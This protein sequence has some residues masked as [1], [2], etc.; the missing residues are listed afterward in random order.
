MRTLDI[1]SADTT[2]LG[3][4]ILGL[5]LYLITMDLVIWKQVQGEKVNKNNSAHV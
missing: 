4:K 5:F 1:V 2:Y 3:V